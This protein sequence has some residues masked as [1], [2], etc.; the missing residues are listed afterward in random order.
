MMKFTCISV[1][2]ALSCLC[3]LSIE[4]IKL[5]AV[6]MLP[7]G[8]PYEIE[9][10]DGSIIV[11]RLTG[12]QEDP[13]EEDE[14]GYPIIGAGD[15]GSDYEYAVLDN[16]SGNLVPSGVKA[17]KGSR[18]PSNAVKH[19]KRTEAGKQAMGFGGEGVKG[20]GKGGKRMPK[21]GALPT[22]RLSHVDQYDDWSEAIEDFHRRTAWTG[23]KRNLVVPMIFKGHE[24]RWRPT[25]AELTVLFN[26]N[27]T[28]ATYAPTGSVRDMFKASSYNKL[29]MVSDVMDWIQLNNTEAYYAD[30]NRG[31][32][33]VVHQAMRDALI[34]LDNTV[35]LNFKNYDLDN[36]G[37]IDAICFLHTG[38]A[39]EW[40]GN[41]EDGANYLNRIWS[42]KWSLYSFRYPTSTSPQGF[43]SKQGV[44]VYNYHISPAIWGTSLNT[45]GVPKTTVN[46]IG[47]VGVI[48]H[49]TGHFLGITDLYDTG[50]G[51][52][53]SGIGS[54]GLMANS[55]GFNNDQRC[56][57]IMCPWSKI[58]LGWLTPKALNVTGNYTITPSYTA[59]DVYKITK[60]YPANEYMLIEYRRKLGFESCMPRQ[61]LAVWKVDDNADYNIQGWPG[62]VGWPSNG[63]HYRISLLQADG[64]YQLEKATNRGDGGDLYYSGYRTFLGPGLYN[65]TTPV[66]PN[67]DS[68]QAGNIVSTGIIIK[69][70]GVPGTTNIKFEVNFPAGV[71]NLRGQ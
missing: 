25:K 27:G 4:S 68:Y 14:E 8:V 45:N 61:G 41:S 44:R 22:R 50:S 20:R 24:T 29:D 31:M 6:A 54:Y 16:E 56:I 49:E 2:A 65:G 53:G 51:D 9:Q 32:T 62:Q 67:T 35:G 42:H 59:Q 19:Q 60:G 3:L 33:I 10:P 52:A 23:T 48:A 11:A 37:L 30:G 26:N 38:F 69:N 40:G 36:D 46:K 28:N 57:P 43:T 18:P 1:Q 5:S 7:S 12:S 47:R 64:L 17:R 13:Y 58:Q 39:A 21:G 34:Y 63:K 15:S 71:R 66:Y 55:W 70:V